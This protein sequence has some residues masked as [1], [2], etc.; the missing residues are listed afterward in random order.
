MIIAT[1]AVHRALRQV[2]ML[3]EPKGSPLPHDA[4]EVILACIRHGN[5]IY[6]KAGFNGLLT[7]QQVVTLDDAPVTLEREVFLTSGHGWK[8]LVDRI[9]TFAKASDVGVV[10]GVIV[11]IPF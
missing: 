6:V 4:I 9:I 5:V 10:S 7:L 1:L 11:S 8:Q 3:P 2:L